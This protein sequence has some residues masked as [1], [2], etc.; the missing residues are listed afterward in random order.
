MSYVTIEWIGCQEEYP[1]VDSQPYYNCSDQNSGGYGDCVGTTTLQSSPAWLFNIDHSIVRYCTQDGFDLLHLQGGGST[2]T[3]KNS[4]AYGSMGQQIKT[5][6]AAT[7]VNN[8][9]V[10]NVYA[11]SYDIPGTPP[12]TSAFTATPGLD[13]TFTGTLTSGSNVIT[14]VSTTTGI[15]VGFHLYD[16]NGQLPA[17]ATV[18]AIGTGTI[19]MSSNSGNS[20]S[21]S[22]DAGDPILT[23]VTITSGAVDFNRYMSGMGIRPGTVPVSY[24]STAHT[25]AM[26]QGVSGGGGTSFSQKWNSGLS[27]FGRAG[28]SA[29]VVAVSDKATTHIEF[30]TMFSANYIGWEIAPGGTCDTACSI[31]FKNNVF[32]GFSTDLEPNGNG[33]N[34]NAIYFDSVDI[35]PTLFTNPGS[36]M[37][38][39]ATYGQKNPCPITGYGET[40]YLCTDPQLVDETWHHYGYGN[41]APVSLSSA[42]EGKGVDISGI[43]TDY[44]DYVRPSPPSMGAREFQT[45]PSTSAYF[46]GS[47]VIGGSGTF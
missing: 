16:P 22:M 4:L 44:S 26:S 25:M 15:Q 13:V 33:A 1:I 24:D 46:G 20:F 6:A 2:L 18:T 28:N 10:G 23:G 41:M 29:A 45:N 30:N 40:N 38:N 14:G 21:G 8:L 12:Q 27:Q 47:V 32:F 7:V 31:V 39:N 11:M 3:V 35:S 34:S 9:I 43:T 42:V 17:G 5:G 37:A 19:T 36:A